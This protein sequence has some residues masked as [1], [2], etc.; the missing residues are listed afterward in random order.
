[1]IRGSGIFPGGLAGPIR[2]TESCVKGLCSTVPVVET[3]EGTIVNRRLPLAFILVPACLSGLMMSSPANAASDTKGW[4]AGGDFGLSIGSTQNLTSG[5]VGVTNS[6]DSG[7]AAGARGG[8]TFADGLR[9]ELEFEYRHSSISSVKLLAPG[10]TTAPVGTKT[11]SLS[12][13]TLMSNLWYDFRQS[14]GTL[15]I[16]YPYV[17]AGVGVAEVG[18][19]DENF[20]SFLDVG[21]AANGSA[22]TFAYQLGFGANCEITPA[23]IASLDVRYLM[24]TSFSI[25]EQTSNGGPGNL[26]G[27]YRVPS[28]FLGLNY[29][30][31]GDAS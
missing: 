20:N 21:G 12:S 3:T 4:Y 10:G 16:L 23:L 7:L 2:T 15:S 13:K 18:I 6:Y 11:G 19:K 9:P 28:I 22:T 29:K 25:P 8:Y 5:N 1:M 26:N 14:E 27:Q 17:G 24:T 31:G 30:F